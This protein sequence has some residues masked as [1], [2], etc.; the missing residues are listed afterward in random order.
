MG[1]HFAGY[2]F[3]SAF[4][5]YSSGETITGYVRNAKTG[6]DFCSFI[7]QFRPDSIPNYVV[8][9]KVSA[10]RQVGCL[11]TP[12]PINAAQA[13]QRGTHGSRAWSLCGVNHTLSSARAM[14]GL[15]ELLTAPIQPWDAVICTSMASREVI[16]K[17]FARQEEYLAKRLGA[18]RFVRPQLPVIPLGVDYVSQAGHSRHRTEARAVLRIEANDFVILFLGRLSFHAKANPAPMYIALERLASRHRVVLIECGWTANNQI[19]QALAEARAK[20]CPSVRSLVLDGREPDVRTRAWAAADIFCSLSDNIQETFGLTPIEAMAA[21]LPVVV[22]DWDGY[23]DTVRNGIDGFS[24][25]TLAAPSG[26]GQRLASRHA[27]EVDSYDSYI[28]QASTAVSVDIDATAAAFKQLASDRDLRRRMG[29]SGAARAREVFD[30]KVIIK[31]YEELWREL[32]ELRRAGEPSSDSPQR[33]SGCWPARPD[34]FELFASFPSASLSARH[35]FIQS[36]GIDEAEVVAR[37]A[38]KIAMVN[39]LPDVSPALLLDLWKQVGN[40][41]ASTRDIL[42][43]RP[44]SVAALIIRSLLLLAKLGLLRIADPA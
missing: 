27:L 15:T 26:A 24:I 18:S 13:W 14:D 42:Q 38:L 10:L 23:K 31:A 35:V 44:D 43:Q 29:E 19:A 33:T 32:A 30:W 11:F 37:L 2:G 34:P 36:P 5:R 21:G 8:T 7:K 4:A 17:L 9:A 6:E 40:Q 39:V 41:G 16:E 20:L 1:R 22:T 3:L 12:S 28:A 25:P